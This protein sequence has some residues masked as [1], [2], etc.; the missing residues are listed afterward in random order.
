MLTGPSL[1]VANETDLPSATYKK[2]GKK[3]KIF[4]VRW[5]GWGM[6]CIF[7]CVREHMEACAVNRPDS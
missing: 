4:G 5:P 2:G 1:P 3:E 6:V 7:V